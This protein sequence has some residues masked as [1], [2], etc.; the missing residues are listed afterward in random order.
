MW[1][2]IDYCIL[3]IW[4]EITAILLPMGFQNGISTC[5]IMSVLTDYWFKN[6]IQVN[7]TILLSLGM[8]SD[9]QSNDPPE[10]NCSAL[11]I[12]S[13]KHWLYKYIWYCLQFLWVKSQKRNK[14]SGTTT[15][16]LHKFCKWTTNIPGMKRQSKYQNEHK[17]H[18][19]AGDK[20][21]DK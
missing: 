12:C 19:Q 16:I 17:E 11:C 2:F 3:Y 13:L 9:N 1:H 7:Y 4:G 15:R 5:S 10:M 14:I 6:C 20:S 21:R 8:S 18:Y